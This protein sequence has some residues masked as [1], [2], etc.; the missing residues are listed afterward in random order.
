MVSVSVSNAPTTPRSVTIHSGKDC[1]DPLVSSA[2]AIPLQPLSGG[3]VSRTIVS[4][5]IQSF[6][7]SNFVVAVRDATARQQALE[8]CARMGP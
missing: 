4:V 7:S 5:P 8:A 6:K 2:G 3:Q 1:Q